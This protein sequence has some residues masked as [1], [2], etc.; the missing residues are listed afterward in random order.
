M[1]ELVQ[2]FSILVQTFFWIEA[3]YFTD[4]EKWLGDRKNLEL[5][6]HQFYSFRHF[7]YFDENLQCANVK[8]SSRQ[9]SMDRGRSLEGQHVFVFGNYWLCLHSRQQQN[10]LCCGKKLPDTNFELIHLFQ[11]R[12]EILQSINVNQWAY[13]KA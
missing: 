4:W 1:S 8:T 7:L 11:H 10:D 12:I 2:T 13:I 5:M 6:V 9:N 3:C